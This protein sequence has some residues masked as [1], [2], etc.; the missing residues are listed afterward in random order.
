MYD[1][2]YETSKPT[3]ILHIRKWLK[4]LIDRSLVLGTVDRASL[5]DLV[6]DFTI[7]MHSKAEL[8]GAHRRVVEAFRV[9]RPTNA[10]GIAQWDA[11]NRDDAVT[12][13]VLD[14]GASHVQ[15]SRDPS[16]SGSDEILLSWLADQ[17]QD[18]LV[19]HVGSALGEDALVSAAEAAE[20]AGEMWLASCRWAAAAR[21]VLYSRGM[22]A[23]VV[24][25]H[26][27]A[28][29]LSRVKLTATAS[30]L[31]VW[32]KDQLELTV[33]SDLAVY[34]LST[35]DALV[36]RMERL[37]T[38]DAAKAQPHQSYSLYVMWTA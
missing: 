3:S 14:E 15:N 17:P 12:A 28:D 29:A 24:P 27:A 34:D 1:A 19:S 23:V 37:L 30:R 13:Y 8:T 11:A 35:A 16:E 21:F 7:G 9:N 25:L 10:A 20:S 5:H 2:V 32:Q 4:L 33:V 38:T 36:P 18:A 31:S 22:V 6:L 26:R